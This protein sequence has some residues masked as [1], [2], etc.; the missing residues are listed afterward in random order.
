MKNKMLI[1]CGIIIIATIFLCGCES[2]DT[3]EYN[4]VPPATYTVTY[5][6]DSI[7]TWETVDVT[8]TNQDGGTSQYTDRELPFTYTLYGMHDDD[9][10]Y[11]SGQINGDGC[12]E[13]QIYLDDILVKHS[14][15]CGKYVIATCSGRI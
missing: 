4:Y 1:L 11:I 3:N 8:M 15:S 14:Q 13:A 7:W 10:V 5:K 12:I 2:T 9:F 6:I